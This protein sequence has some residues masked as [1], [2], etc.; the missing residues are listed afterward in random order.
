VRG[1][2]SLVL[3][4]FLCLLLLFGVLLQ[5]LPSRP[6]SSPNSVYSSDPWGR[7][8]ALALLRELGVDARPWSST[9]GDLPSDGGLLFLET[10]PD[11]PPGY[12][13]AEEGERAPIG[14]A[15]RRRLRDPLHYLRFVEDGGTLVLPGQP[16]TIDFL[17]DTFELAEFATL[18]TAAPWGIDGPLGTNPVRAVLP[19]GEAFDVPWTPGQ[20]YQ[21]F[22]PGS[23]FEVIL[24]DA[25][26]EAVGIRYPFGRGALVLLQDQELSGATHGE[27]LG[28]LDN[29]SIEKDDAALFLV[30]LV[31]F[32]ELEG[33]VLFD[34]YVLDRWTPPSAVELAF[35]PASFLFS[36]HLVA[37][38]LVL[39][40][41]V[42]WTRQ[43]PRDPVTWSSI[44]A[45]V[46]ARGFAGLLGRAGRWDLLGRMLGEGVLRRLAAR[47][48]H[49]A[50]ALGEPPFGETAVRAV[51][52]PLSAG[53]DSEELD[54][55]V[56]LFHPE[57]SAGLDREGL[58]R[59]GAELAR[60]E[61]DALAHSH[62]GRAHGRQTQGD[63]PS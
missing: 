26:G 52:A 45:V 44:S 24:A 58:E 21:P 53:L 11:I 30:R 7:S 1:R 33:P 36:A 54:R 23:P 63:E 9:P 5:F 61:R 55:R 14:D 29:N 51:L 39:L 34:E 35:S 41:C 20:R 60:V 32:F 22:P 49:S 46:R 28:F 17:I 10:P 19:T 38:V 6:E 15:N 4:A 50:R 62:D 16:D 37:L 25:E 48:G 27:G 59:L 57:R 12:G 3:L 42:A 13:P 47:S 2:G 18:E 56:R 31:E 43:F 8:V 40:W